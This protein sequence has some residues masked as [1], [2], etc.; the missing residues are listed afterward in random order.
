MNNTNTT[1]NTDNP[2]FENLQYI[3]RQK[4]APIPPAPQSGQ[5]QGCR[6]C[7]KKFLSGHLNICPSK[8]EVCKIFQKIG[9]FAK[10]C[11]S[12]MPRAHNTTCNKQDKQ[13]TLDN[14]SKGANNWF[15]SKHYKNE[16]Y[17]RR[18]NKE[19]TGGDRRNNRLRI[20]MLHTRNYGRLAVPKF[21]T[22][23]KIHRRKSDRNQQNK[24]RRF[25]DTS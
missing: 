25:L 17:K 7:G 20:N 15:R 22:I 6:S 14:N 1:T 5:I 11:R 12:E 4:R 19:H 10:L 8:N 21:F 3:K 2:W 18:R 24:K 16:E 9:N 13:F 23:S